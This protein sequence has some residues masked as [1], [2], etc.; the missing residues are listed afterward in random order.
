VIIGFLLNA[1]A[2][3]GTIHQEDTAATR[4]SRV[5]D[6]VAFLELTLN[7]IGGDNLLQKEKDI[8]ITQSYTKFFRDS[9]VQIEDDL[10]PGRSTVT[11][12]D[13]QAY[14]KD[15][16]FFFNK[17]SFDLVIEEVQEM[18]NDNDLTFYLVKLNRNLN[19]I[20]I[21]GDTLNQTITRFLEI[22]YDDLADDLKIVSYYTTKLSEKEDLL[23]WWNELTFEWKYILQNKVDFRDSIGY[24]ELKDLVSMD[25][26]DLSSN[27]YIRDFDPLLKLDQL[28][29]LNLS[30]THID[31]LSPLRVHNKIEFLDISDTPVEDLG[32]LK[33][34]INMSQL[35]IAKTHLR[36]VGVLSNFIKL[37]YLDLSESR[38]DSVDNILLPPSLNTLVYMEADMDDYNW[39]SNLVNLKYLDLSFSSLDSIAPL[40]P[41]VNLQTLI[42]E[43]TGISDLSPLIAF[44][45]L[46]VL[47]IESTKV[48]DIYGLSQ[49]RNLRKVYC[50]HSLV[51]KTQADNF[52]QRFPGILVIFESDELRVWWADLPQEWKEVYRERFGVSL[53]PEKDEL[54]RITQIDSID[55][56]G[57]KKISTLDG[58]APLK[59]L[60]YLDFNNT[61][62]VKVNTM[63]TLTEL[64]YVDGSYSNI[65]A[66][67]SIGYLKN[68]EYLNLESTRISDIKDLSRIRGLKYLNLDLTAVDQLAVVDLKFQNPECLIIYRTHYLKT[69]WDELDDMWKRVFRENAGINDEPDED[70][71]HKIT[72]LTAVKIDGVNI[73]DLQPLNELY[74]LKE[75][76]IN[77]TGV[78]DLSPLKKNLSL[79]KLTINQSPVLDIS[80]LIQLNKLTYLDISSTG[81][82]DIDMLADMSKLEVIKMSGIQIKD[83]K[84]LGSLTGIK[85][86]D[87]S[88]T[89]VKSLSPIQSLSDLEMLVCYN[90]RIKDKVIDSFKELHPD[91]QIVY[92]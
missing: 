56:S 70:D 42:V 61:F 10:D 76:N 75:L 21:T 71:L 6:L 90:T 22:N 36:D 84:P 46:E 66:I 80:M 88:N 51:T 48:S 3:S 43:G 31:D 58:L 54:A 41:L 62:V 77:R 9:E 44:K 74:Y 37:K 64:R 34:A 92:Y 23:N 85:Q 60:R 69:W 8:I 28:R 40:T 5:K 63:T 91:C 14:L 15:V 47:N 82:N 25:S 57:N 68:L 1:A 7:N 35:K 38:I 4:I 86:L 16:D 87:I 32:F 17:V 20:T 78:R 24:E 11:N 55:I 83:I 79:E 67:D 89:Q 59:K 65:T 27:H 72:Y 18:V 2:A 13:V 45:S 12:K 30:N 53:N 50:D 73:A 29:Y 49:L 26:L 39:L 81:I 33:Y 19:G 52:M